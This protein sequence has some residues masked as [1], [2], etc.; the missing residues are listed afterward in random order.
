MTFVFPNERGKGLE[1]GPT[2]HLQRRTLSHF[3]IPFIHVATARSGPGPPHFRGSMIT[4]GHSA[5]S[6]I[7]LDER[8]DRNF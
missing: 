2:A 8:L 1:E 7:L 6:R 4:I 5:L 3:V